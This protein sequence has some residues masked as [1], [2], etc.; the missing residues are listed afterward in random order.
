MPAYCTSEEKNALYDLGFISDISMSD[1]AVLRVIYE[2][3]IQ[4]SWFVCTVWNAVSAPESTSEDSQDRVLIGLIQ[5]LLRFPTVGVLS[6]SSLKFILTHLLLKHQS[7]VSFV[8]VQESH[9]PYGEVVEAATI[10]VSNDTD[11]SNSSGVNEENRLKL[12]MDFLNKAN[13]VRAFFTRLYV[14]IFLVVAYVATSGYEKKPSDSM[15]SVLESL[16]L[17][18]AIFMCFSALIPFLRFSIS[19]LSDV[20]QLCGYGL[21]TTEEKQL[22]FGVKLYDWLTTKMFR[23]PLQDALFVPFRGVSAVIAFGNPLSPLLV[24]LSMILFSISTAKAWSTYG[25]DSMRYDAFLSQLRDS[26]WGLQHWR[27]YQ[28]H[29]NSM[30]KGLLDDSKKIAS[31]WTLLFS[32]ALLGFIGERTASKSTSL[33][34]ACGVA[35]STFPHIALEW[36]RGKPYRMNPVHHLVSPPPLSSLSPTA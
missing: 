32:F 31:L 15:Q 5:G 3:R 22:P 16:G 21:K 17:G 4:I 35:V 10:T 29:F 9:A 1:E 11:I 33:A 34:A 23:Q 26:T 19:M 24:M 2:N 18:R 14:V 25:C 30:E 36:M 28:S 7:T 12:L 20:P 6:E 13:P 8:D 27:S